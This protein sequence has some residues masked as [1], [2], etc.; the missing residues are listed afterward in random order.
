MNKKMLIPIIIAGVAI[1]IIVI[2]IILLSLG[3]SSDGED[4][5]IDMGATQENTTTGNEVE[6]TTT[7]VGAQMAQQEIEMYNVT[8]SAYLGTGKRGVDVRAL[9]DAI[10]MSNTTNADSPGKF[11]ALDVTNISAET[12]VIGAAGTVENT[13]EYVTNISSQMTTFKENINAGSTYDV[14]ATYTDSG[15]ITSIVVKQAGSGTSTEG[16]T[17]NTTT[18]GTLAPTATN[19]MKTDLQERL[20]TS[21]EA[22]VT[23]FTETNPTGTSRDLATYIKS[24]LDSGEG[25]IKASLPTNYVISDTVLSANSLTFKVTIDGAQ[26][27][28]TFNAIERTITVQ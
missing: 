23:T 26:C 19:D 14:E 12:G 18:G 6:N 22:M 10:I 27:N 21:I 16:G 28:V 15:L 25:T 24:D 4:N 1:V 7:D 2:A 17:T 9:I 3:Q 5:T 8:L 11:V 20:E 13:A